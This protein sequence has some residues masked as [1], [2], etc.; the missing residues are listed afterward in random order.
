MKRRQ[1]LI[2]YHKWYLKK[3]HRAIQPDE[4][5]E[6]IVDN[7]LTFDSYYKLNKN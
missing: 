1:L 2:K 4:V 7:F 6:E 5:I 3:Y